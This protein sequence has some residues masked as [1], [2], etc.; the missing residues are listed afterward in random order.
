MQRCISSRSSAVGTA[1]LAWRKPVEAL[2]RLV[3]RGLAS[4]RGMALSR[5][6]TCARADR[7]GAAEHH[8][9]DERVRSQPVRA[10]DR[11]AGRLAHRHQAGRDAV[12]FSASAFSTS[13]Q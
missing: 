10:V 8:E 2:E 1:P 6:T 5:S 13:P 7:R 9:V 12:G 4:A 3:D 11:G